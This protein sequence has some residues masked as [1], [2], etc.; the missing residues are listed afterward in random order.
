MYANCLNR[1]LPVAK[2]AVFSVRGASAGELSPPPPIFL[3]IG[4][5]TRQKAGRPFAV[6]P[7]QIEGCD[8]T[9]KREREPTFTS[10]DTCL[11][12]A[13]SR[14]K[15]LCDNQL[16]V[17]RCR[18]AG[19]SVVKVNRFAT[20]AIHLPTKFLAGRN[21][22]PLRRARM[23]TSFPFGSIAAISFS[24]GAADV[25]RTNRP[26][27]ISFSS[28]SLSVTSGKFARADCGGR[29]A[30]SIAARLGS[31]SRSNRADRKSTRLNS[32]H[33]T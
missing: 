11:L 22:S 16:W 18:R 24:S 1:R 9:S 28:S 20:G 21:S 31:C 30:S 13:D 12:K 14:R 4:E 29:R 5:S 10:G 8:S 26:W 17:A 33:R 6:S 23:A 25:Q 32:S 3:R 7:C 27:A 19:S 15:S 2:R